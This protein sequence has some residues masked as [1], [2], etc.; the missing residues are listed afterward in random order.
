MADNKL[1][2]LLQQSPPPTNTEIILPEDEWGN[3]V[4]LPI[5]REGQEL[6]DHLKVLT[7]P[8]SRFEIDLEFQG[9]VPILT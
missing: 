7:V 9:W 2:S 8:A 6:S 1:L 3:S 5:R 4:S